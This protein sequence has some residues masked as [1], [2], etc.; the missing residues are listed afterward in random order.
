VT[1]RTKI[2]FS[3]G[4][5]DDAIYG[6]DNGVEVFGGR[7]IA[8]TLKA[9]FERSGY[10]VSDPVDVGDHGWALDIWS[11]RRRMSLQVSV[12]DTDENYLVAESFGFWPSRKLL[13]QL[14]GDLQRILEADG[15]FSQI[16]WLP[17]RGSG[18]HMAPAAGPFDP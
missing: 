14:L 13:R 10:R 3:S 12:I 17:M 18:R 11:G 2:L 1:L 9:A 8:E 6:A 4:F 7:N 15:R 5:P 16:G